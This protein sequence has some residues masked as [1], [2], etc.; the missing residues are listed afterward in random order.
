[1]HNAIGSLRKWDINSIDVGVPN[2]PFLNWRPIITTLH[3]L[4][5]WPSDCVVDMHTM[6]H[7]YNNMHNM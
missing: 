7:M 2:T 5:A 1:M 3:F 6:A 4:S